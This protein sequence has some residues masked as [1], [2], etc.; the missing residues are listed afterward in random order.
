MR[1]L[2]L[3]FQNEVTLEDDRMMRLEYKLTENHSTDNEEPYYGIQIIKYLDDN[4]EMEEVKGVSYS[5]DKVK[6]MAKILFQHVV[7]P[8]SMVEIIDDL[9]TLE[10]CFM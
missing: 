4:L 6:S 8:I 2:E 5:K 1:K 3:L 9:I 7:T 10:S